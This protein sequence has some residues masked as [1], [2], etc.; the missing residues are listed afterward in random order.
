VTEHNLHRRSREQLGKLLFGPDPRR[1]K[2]ERG[3]H[4]RAVLRQDISRDS[5]D[6]DLRAAEFQ[7]SG[8]RS[9]KFSR[10][11]VRKIADRNR[12]GSANASNR[13]RN[14]GEFGFVIAEVHNRRRTSRERR[15]HR[16]IDRA[17][18][19]PRDHVTEL[20]RVS[21]DEDRERNRSIFQQQAID[22]SDHLRGARICGMLI[23][24]H[25][26]YRLG[27]RCAE[28][29]GQSKPSNKTHRPTPSHPR[30][31]AFAD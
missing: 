5:G 12:S 26:Q 9:K 6:N 18:T 11:T 17:F 8:R 22:V 7:S 25:H 15:K 27:V 31:N 23:S 2:V 28:T 1:R 4:R 14:I 19:A 3:L 24:Q 10:R 21:V 13:C 20:E 16:K 30:E 29:S